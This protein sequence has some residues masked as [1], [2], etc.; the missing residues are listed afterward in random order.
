MATTAPTCG[1][2]APRSWACR[3]CDSGRWMCDGGKLLTASR[4]RFAAAHANAVGHAICFS[5]NHEPVGLA[6]AACV[7][8]HGVRAGHCATGVRHAG[9]RVRRRRAAG[10]GALRGTRLSS[11]PM[12]SRHLL[13]SLCD[14][15]CSTLRPGRRPTASGGALWTAAARAAPPST[16]VR[17]ARDRVQTVQHALQHCSPLAPSA[18]RRHAP[19]PHGAVR[20]RRVQ[21]AR[22]LARR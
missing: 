18:R 6:V 13:H 10:A 11:V 15:R 8:I 16:E 22:C 21:R 5:D 4:L 20:V 19:L 2:R 1:R 9:C 14:R 12:R 7:P 17:P 3:R